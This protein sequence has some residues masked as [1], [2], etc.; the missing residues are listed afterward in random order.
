MTESGQQ[1]QQQ[2]QQQQLSPEQR[3]ARAGT[4]IREV[5]NWMELNYPQHGRAIQMLREAGDLVTG[6]LERMQQ[7]QRGA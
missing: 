5:Q 3:L 1:Q 7:Q 2:E 4:A 6:E